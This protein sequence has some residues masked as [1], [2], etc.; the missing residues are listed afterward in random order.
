MVKDQCISI[1][2]LRRNAKKVL[3]QLSQVGAQYIFVNNR[4][5]AVILDIDEYEDLSGKTFLRRLPDSEVTPEMKKKIEETKKI[6]DSEL[7]NL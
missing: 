4:P 5:K 6:P 7:L 1:T 2:D 3:D